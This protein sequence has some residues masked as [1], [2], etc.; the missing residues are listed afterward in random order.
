MTF[1]VRRSVAARN[2]L[3]EI[4]VRIALHDEAA[5]DRHLDRIEDGIRLLAD[6]PRSGP[7]REELLPGFRAVLRAPYLILYQIDD[8]RR[9]IDIVRV[10]DARRDLEAALHE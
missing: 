9:R 6:F 3:I 7:A 5:A 10:I 4:W 2:D 1:A 8:E